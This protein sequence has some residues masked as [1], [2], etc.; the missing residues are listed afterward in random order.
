MGSAVH[1]LTRSQ[2]LIMKFV[3]ALLFSAGLAF[4]A[5]EGPNAEG[6]PE[7][8]Y[9]GYYGYPAYS[10]QRWGGNYG[11]Y[12]GGYYG[13]PYGYG[14]YGRK[15]RDAEADPAVLAST[16]AVKAPQTYTLPYTYG[17]PY[18]HHVGVPLTYTHAVTTAPVTYTVPHAL[19][20]AHHYPYTY[21]YGHLPY[22]IKPA[23][24]AERK[25]RDAEPEADADPEAWYGHYYG[26]GGYGRYY[27]HGG[28]YGGY[29][30]YPRYGYYGWGK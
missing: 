27:G 10:V 1:T 2:H 9:G 17:Y 11:G 15:K 16:S 18:A 13:H 20:Y 28:Y 8:W 14:Y 24:E 19:T 23:E 26:Y 5:E 6:S 3:L 7:S 4:A 22:L 12:Y 29:Y 21:G 30:G 25:K